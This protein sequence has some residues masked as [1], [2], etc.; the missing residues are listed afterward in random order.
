MLYEVVISPFLPPQIKLLQNNP[1]FKN[2]LLIVHIHDEMS[3]YKP[4]FSFPSVSGFP[5]MQPLNLPFQ[6]LVRLQCSLLSALCSLNV[7]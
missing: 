6:A 3:L 4:N 5:G 1:D 7:K 2:M